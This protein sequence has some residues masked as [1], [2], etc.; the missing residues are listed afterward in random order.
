VKG[1]DH[2][3]RQPVDALAAYGVVEAVTRGAFGSGAPAPMRKSL[4]EW[5]RGTDRHAET[6]K[7]LDETMLAFRLARR[8]VGETKGCLRA[9]RQ[10][11][12]IPVDEVARRLGVCR[13]EVFRLEKSENESRI[14]L[15]TLRRAAAALDCELV[16]GLTPRE[17]TLEELAAAQKAAHEKALEESHEKRRAEVMATEEKILKQIGW[18]RAILKNFRRGL[19]EAGM[20]VR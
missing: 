14:M 11:V 6:R 13:W 19:R 3:Q 10:A 1:D 20:K 7:K 18:R 2:T 16:Y 8:A 17:G 9:V 12:G 15:N 4:G 5:R